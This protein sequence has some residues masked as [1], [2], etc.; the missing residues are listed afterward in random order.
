MNH[1][2]VSAAALVTSAAA[3][4]ALGC[5]T[6]GASPAGAAHV[7]AAAADSGARTGDAARTTWKPCALPTGYRHFF[8]LKSAKKVHGDTVV[9]VVPEQCVVNTENDEDVDYTPTGPATSLVVTSSA[10]V[11][12]LDGTRTVKVSP[13]WLTNHTLDNT[14]HF[15]YRTGAGNRITAM[16]EIYHP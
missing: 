9:R 2:S 15:V 4:L 11:K 13:A 5:G 12:V 10:S 14:P 16:R 7:R 1:R 8:E 6:A 3:L